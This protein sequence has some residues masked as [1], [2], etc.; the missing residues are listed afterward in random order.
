MPTCTVIDARRRGLVCDWEQTNVE[1]EG[2]DAIGRECDRCHAPTERLEILA[3]R[4]QAVGRNEHAAALALLGASRG[5]FAR[6]AAL[7]PK[8]R[9]EIA[10]AAAHARWSK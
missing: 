7:T 8:R 1:P 10:R 6:A 4:V 5:G 3:R 2:A 9:R